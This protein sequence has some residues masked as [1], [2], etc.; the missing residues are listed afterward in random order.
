MTRGAARLLRVP[1]VPD[2]GVGRAGGDR[3]HR[4]A[5]DR[6]DARPQRP[7]PRPLVRDRRRLGR[8]RV[9]DGR[10]RRRRRRT[11]CARDG[12]SR[13]SSSS[14]T[15][16]RA[17]SSPTRRRSTQSRRGGRTRS[18]SS[19]EQLRLAELPPAPR[20]SRRPSRCAARQLLFGY[21]QEDMKA[22]LA[23]LARNAEEPVGSMGNDT[24]LAVLTGRKPLLYSYFKQLFAQV[25]NPPIDSIRE[26]IVMS[27]RASVGSERNLLDETPEHARQL[28]I[29]NPIL[30]DGEL[31]QLRRVELRRLHSRGRSTRRGPPPKAPTASSARSSASAHEANVALAAGANILILSDR[32]AGPGRV[33]IPSLLATGA[34][35]HHLVREGTRLQAGIVVESGEPRSVH[36]IAALV[37]YGAAAVNPYLMLETLARARRARLAPAG[38]DGR[39]RRRR[40]ATKGIAKG[41]LKTMSK[42]GISTMPSYCGA[43][44]FEA[45]GLAPG[46][47]RAALHRHRV[48]HRRHRHPRARRGVARAAR[49][50]VPR[51]RRRAAA[52]DRP[53]RV[54][55]RRRAPPLEPGHDLDAAA[56]GALGLGRD[57][58]G[59]L[60]RRERRERARARRC[61]AR[62]A[63]ARRERHPA[64]GRSSPRR[65]S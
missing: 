33:P 16:R 59:V 3:V 8:A 36:S 5:R 54:A 19:S 14:S 61:A 17:A 46:A 55:P 65:R 47:R 10:A 57:V 60:A 56:R 29:D 23:P 43:Q 22:I 38:D 20:P 63:S 35:H 28:V 42:M 39:A 58:R 11:S 31:E 25:T 64:R 53:L 37:G 50:R 13:A 32:S 9:G 27:V 44:I 34:V 2:G 62:S 18:G 4:R 52:G 24:P 49:A 15:S 6:R 51:R 1:P 21:A 12:C 26:A 40:R 48:A 30:L 45:V 41:L 7:P